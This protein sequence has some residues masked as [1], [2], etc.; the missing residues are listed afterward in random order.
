MA[1]RTSH[2]YKGKK[3][4]ESVATGLSPHFE[5]LIFYNEDQLIMKGCR[6]YRLR[7]TSENPASN[8][9]GRGAALASIG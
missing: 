7:S 4:E 3:I 9:M 5:V 1:I 2:Q 6:L 8:P